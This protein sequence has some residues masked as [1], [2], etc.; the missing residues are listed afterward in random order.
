MEKLQHSKST[1]NFVFHQNRSNQNTRNTLREDF[2]ENP[3]DNIDE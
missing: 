1:K 3:N 2:N